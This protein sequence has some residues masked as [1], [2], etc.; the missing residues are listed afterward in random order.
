MTSISKTT[1]YHFTNISIHVRVHKFNKIF[2][3]IPLETESSKFSITASQSTSQPSLQG[4]K[5]RKTNLQKQSR[6]EIETTYAYARK[7]KI[8]EYKEYMC[9]YITQ[10]DVYVYIY[11]Y[12][13]SKNT[14]NLN[15]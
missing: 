6:N 3:K 7:N 14:F 4:S 5:K 2:N 15:M 10:R 9:V 12:A 8:S 1:G 11:I 13:A